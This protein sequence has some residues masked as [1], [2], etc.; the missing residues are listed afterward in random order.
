MKIQGV[1]N[2]TG[3]TNEWYGAAVSVGNDIFYAPSKANKILKVT[4][5]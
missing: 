4:L 3:A 1:L 5:P 2:F